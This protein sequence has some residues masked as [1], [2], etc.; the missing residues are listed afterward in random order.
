VLHPVNKAA[1]DDSEDI[2]IYKAVSSEP[3]ELPFKVDGQRTFSVTFTALV[4]E[5]YTSTRR[6][7]HIGSTNIS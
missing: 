7:G 2:V 1:N 5:G 6:L 4:D 3:I